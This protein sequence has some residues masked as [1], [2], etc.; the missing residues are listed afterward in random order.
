[1]WNL[2]QGCGYKSFGCRYADREAPS[3]Q[4]HRPGH[5]HLDTRSDGATLQGDQ[6]MANATQRNCTPAAV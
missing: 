3:A 5:Q 4:A 6:T 1:M 2:G